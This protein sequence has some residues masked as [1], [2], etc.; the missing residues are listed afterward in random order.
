MIVPPRFE[1]PASCLMIHVDTFFVGPN[2]IVG[3]GGV[4]S[5]DINRNCLL[6]F[7]K[8]V[9][10]NT[11]CAAGLL[12][13]LEAMQC[14]KC[15]GYQNAIIYADC[16]NTVDLILGDRADI[17]LNILTSCRQWLTTNMRILI[18]HCNRQLNLV[19]ESTA[20]ACRSIDATCIVSRN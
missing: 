12:A 13:I 3:I 17:Y 1:H 11:P 7:G 2:D 10:T 15:Q 20:K 19:A 6:G 18:K 14:V 8:R 16:K 5:W 4:V 9:Y